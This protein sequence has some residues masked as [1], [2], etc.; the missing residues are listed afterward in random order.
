[1]MPVRLPAELDLESIDRLALD[2][3]AAISAPGP[4]VLLTGTTA[5]VFC[6]GAAPGAAASGESDTYAFSRVL[7]AMHH[8]PKPLLAA[9]DGAAAGAGVGIASACDWV[10]ATEDSTFGLPELLSGRVPAIIW[11]LLV[12]RMPPHMARQWALSGEPR[13]AI[14]A[15]EAGLVD[16]VVA[17]NQLT[18]GVERAVVALERVDPSA[19]TRLRQWSRSSRRHELPTALSMG[20]EISAQL[21][22]HAAF[23]RTPVI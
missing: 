11:P 17:A 1:M 13:S 19:L 15:R 16:E 18:A 6:S 8:S 12:E 3:A 7:A 14:L 9:V 23:R 20:V 21:R 2:L 5:G 22:P 10:V 4:I